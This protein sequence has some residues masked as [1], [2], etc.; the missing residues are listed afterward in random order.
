[1]IRLTFKQMWNKRRS[2]GWIFIELVLVT[3]FMWKA[4][5]PVF[6]I[7]C[8]KTIDKGYNSTNAF[9]LTFG[10]YSSAHAKYDETQIGDSLREVN[11]LRIYEQ[12][13]NYTGVTATS[14]VMNY[15]HPSS[16]SYSGTG[17][18]YDSLGTGGRYY[19]FYK[20]GEYFKV[21]GMENNISGNPDTR[22]FSTS[23]VYFTEAMAHKLFN[24]ENGLNHT[25]TNYNGSIEFNVAGIVDKFKT[26][27]LEQPIPAAFMPTDKLNISSF[28]FCMQICFRIHD[29]VSPQ[30]FAERFKEEFVPRMSLGNYY[31]LDLTNFETIE[32]AYE[33][34]KGYTNTVRLQ[35]SLVVFFLLCTFLG[36]SGTFWLRT[37]SRRG[38]IGLRIAMG[39]TPRSILK[40]FLTESVLLTT[41]AWL[42][43]MLI[44]SQLVFHSGFDSRDYLG[45]D[46]QYIQNRP[47]P[48]FLIVSFITYIL[49]LLIAL[50][51]TWIPARRAARI[52]PAD[53]LR[54]E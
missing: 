16:Q 9:R 18:K 22:S 11:F 17:F 30:V 33:F 47:V 5:D 42:I 26:S 39:G 27:K 48:H 34:A 29:D 32:R 6:V 46:M 40:N 41:I 4:I 23:S 2:N 37:N 13:R 19:Q 53:A 45:E 31:Y 10:E 28:P 51:G 44:M 49:T 1:M 15:G 3:I 25:V 14:I 36:I 12:L 43:G 38:E 8:N 35:I 52:E 21:F 7:S 50:L 24:G 20:D 54:D